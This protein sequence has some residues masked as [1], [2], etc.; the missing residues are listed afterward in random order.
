MIWFKLVV[1]AFVVFIWSKLWYWF[2]FLICFC[3]SLRFLYE[4]IYLAPKLKKIEA[5]DAI[6]VKT[7]E[8]DKTSYLIPLK[9]ESYKQDKLTLSNKY[10][11]L[12]VSFL[13]IFFLNQN[14]SI[15]I[16]NFIFGDRKY[17]VTTV[18]PQLNG[19]GIIFPEFIYKPKEVD[20]VVESQQSAFLTMKQVAN[21]TK[22]IFIKIIPQIIELDRK[23]SELI[24]LENLAASSD[25]YAAQSHLYLRARQQIQDLR[26]NAEKLHQECKKFIR[27][28]LIGEELARF[29]PDSIPDLASYKFMFDAQYQVINQRYQMLNDEMQAYAELRK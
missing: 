27:E 23:I 1:F 10:P 29:N 7:K 21:P 3:T 2:L 28:V 20:I 14:I 22:D 19:N 9:V 13:N 17:T 6:C 16:L 12:L 8:E 25:V 24:H 4:L 11:Q 5:S 15:K 18:Q 26:S